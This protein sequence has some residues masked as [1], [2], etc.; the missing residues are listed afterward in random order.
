MSEQIPTPDDLQRDDD[1]GIAALLREVGAA[2][3]PPSPMADEVRAKVQAEW[4]AAV[5]VRTRRK[6]FVN[7]GL[8]A[9]V[10]GVAA[11]A[12][13]VWS[14]ATVA[15]PVITVARV[16]GTVE[17]TGSDGKTHA[18]R[19]G[20]RV[21]S[22]DRMQSA[23]NGRAAFEVDADVSVRIDGDSALQVNKNGH[24]LLT[25]GAVYVDA[26]PG[27]DESNDKPGRLIVDTAFGAVRH[28]GT[29]YQVRIVG[30]GI[31][32]GVR[33]GRV[34]VSHSRGT[35][36]GVAG[37]LM[38]LSAVGDVA[39]RALSAFDPRWEWATNAAPAFDIA[40]RSLL[41]FL[42]WSAREMGR[43]LVFDSAEARQAAAVVKLRGTIEGL[44]MSTAL[45]AVLSTTKLQRDQSE[46][47]SLHI[48]LNSTIESKSSDRPTP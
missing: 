33:E 9:S 5:S 16:S 42:R 41:E 7:F 24:L 23:T 18:L 4:L 6:R 1:A 26:V 29:Q 46:D 22:G 39:R 36:S 48:A 21:L 25:G 27:K 20:E 32:V 13:L 3:G 11:S 19:V 28:L 43:E 31:E 12:M 44:D 30:D 35:H 34:E 47:D 40:D 37:E 2:E 8:A 45:T 10:M 15:E 14:I 38:H 17:L